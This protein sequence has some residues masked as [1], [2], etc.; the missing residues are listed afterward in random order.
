MLIEY[1]LF[2]FPILLIPYPS[3]GLREQKI[4]FFVGLKLSDC[5]WKTCHLTE[6][7]E[8]LSN[9]IYV[10]IGIVSDP[11]TNIYIIINL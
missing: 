6:I 8:N 11:Q 5:A 1:I 10:Y 9:Y 4:E 3:K 2:G 7:T